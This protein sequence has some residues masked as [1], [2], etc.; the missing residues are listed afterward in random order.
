[1]QQST[2]RFQI[3]NIESDNVIDICI[4]SILDANGTGQTKG[5]GW[6]ISEASSQEQNGGS[7]GGQGGGCDQ[8][9]PDKTYGNYNYE[10]DFTN[11]T[12]FLGSGGGINQTIDNTTTTKYVE[13]IHTRGGGAIILQA[14]NFLILGLV[15]ASGYP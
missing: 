5:L 2:L 10:Y 6:G 7:F 8:L 12:S 3:I 9:P 14:Q 11:K 1:M 15:S 4:D 13:S